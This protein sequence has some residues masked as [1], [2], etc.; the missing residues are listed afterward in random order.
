LT[1]RPDLTA[2]GYPR[3]QC[4]DCGKQFNE[5]SDG[6]LNRAPLPSDIWTYVGNQAVHQRR[7]G[8]VSLYR[9]RA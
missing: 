9:V 8:C 2:R 6:V 4:R 3:F 1:E 7:I 5:D